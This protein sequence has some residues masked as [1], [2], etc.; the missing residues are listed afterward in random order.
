MRH[1]EIGMTP[2]I[3][4]E[5]L[6]NSETTNT[7]L[8]SIVIPNSVDTIRKNAFWGCENLTIYAR[9]ESQPEGWES[10]WNSDCLVVWNF[11]DE[12]IAYDAMGGELALGEDD[13]NYEIVSV[14]ELLVSPFS[15][16]SGYFLEGWYKDYAYKEKWD[17]ETDT[18]EKSM[19]LVAKWVVI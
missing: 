18:V 10:G 12:I 11:Q 19:V 3:G 17:F 16:R 4:K 7:T 6:T 15:V 5:V 8:R 9:A 14:G 13:E 2:S 1:F